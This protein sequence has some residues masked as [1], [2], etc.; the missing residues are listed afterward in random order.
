MTREEIKSQNAE[1]DRLIQFQNLPP[2]VA[3]NYLRELKQRAARKSDDTAE[4]LEAFILG[5]LFGIRQERARRRK[6]K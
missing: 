6:G 4:W 3:C 5:R 2:Q 1:F